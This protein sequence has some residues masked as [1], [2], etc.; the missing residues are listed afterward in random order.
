MS[1]VKVT[2]ATDP[3]TG[4]G[5]LYLDEKLVFDFGDIGPFEGPFRKDSGFWRPNYWDDALMELF[6]RP[7]FDGFEYDTTSRHQLIED[8]DG[9][10]P[11]K[12]SDAPL[13]ERTYE[14]EDDVR[15]IIYD[16]ILIR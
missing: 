16:T 4:F 2:I 13:D 11:D 5:A 6:A 14:P 8:D 10:W 9:Y 1:Q 7:E 3:H 15:T 12:L